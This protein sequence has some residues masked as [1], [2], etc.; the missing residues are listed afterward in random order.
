MRNNHVNEKGV[1]FWLD[2]NHDKSNHSIIG[3]YDDW[4]TT[5]LVNI[6]TFGV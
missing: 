5:K 1:L 2:M 3:T 4:N 6:K